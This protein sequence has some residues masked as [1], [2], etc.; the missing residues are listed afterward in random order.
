MNQMVHGNNFSPIKQQTRQEQFVCDAFNQAF[1]NVLIVMDMMELNAFHSAVT[2]AHKTK[3]VLM[4]K[5]ANLVAQLA[6]V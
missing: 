5:N 2:F 4:A 3:S 6:Q 1:A